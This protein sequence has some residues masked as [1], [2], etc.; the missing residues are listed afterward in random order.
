MT[1]DNRRSNK[2][3]NFEKQ[4][5]QQNVPIKSNNFPLKFQDNFVAPA[6]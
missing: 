3:Y 4:K 5:V 1:L 6:A 2:Q